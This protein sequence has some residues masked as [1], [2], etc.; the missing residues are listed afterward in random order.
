LAIRTSRPGTGLVG[1]RT[2][3]DDEPGDRGM[4]FITTRDGVEIFY[5]GDK[6]RFN[7]DLL[8]FIES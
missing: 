6:E 1:D 3:T 4:G 7:Q 5:P 8:D 2:A